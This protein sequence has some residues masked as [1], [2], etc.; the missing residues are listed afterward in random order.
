MGEFDATDMDLLK[1][2]VEDSR[3]P[4]SEMADHVELSAPAVRDRIDR[5][6]EAGV[7]RRFTADIDRSLLEGGIPVLVT[8][9]AIPAAIDDMHQALKA[10]DAVEHVYVTADARLIAHLVVSDGEVRELLAE[11]IELD[12]VR[13]FDIDLLETTDWTPRLG[14]ATVA[15]DCAECGNTVT[16]EGESTRLDGTVYHFCCPSCEDRFVTHHEELAEGA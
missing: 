10:S 1:L 8:I 4:Y 15:L 7:I 13:S 14:A 5:L 3:R 12:A 9:D 2:L 6:Q 16:S 11:T